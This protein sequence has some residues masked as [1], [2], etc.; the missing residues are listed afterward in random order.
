MKTITLTKKLLLAAFIS[1]VL[2]LSMTGCSDNDEKTATT[3][4]KAS[5]NPN[6]FDHSGDIK[7][8][9]S[10][11]QKFEQQFAAQCVERE[12]K[13]SSNKEEDRKR[14][15]KPCTCIATFLM[16]DLTGQEAEKFLIEHENPQSLKIKYE[17]AAYHCLQEK[18]PPQE[19]DFSRP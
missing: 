15:E 14:F 10:Q 2:A 17:N 8:T 9:D 13:N 3:K 19:P 4:P 18:V 7:V 12:L 16:K 11:K 5:H 6:P 1:S